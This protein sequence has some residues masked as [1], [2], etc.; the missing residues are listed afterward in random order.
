MN[1]PR[2]NLYISDLDGTLLTPD[3]YFPTEAVNRLNHLIENGLK[4]T[5]ATARSYD[6]AH[7]V[8]S[9]VN[10]NLP[11]ILFNGVYLT[12]FQSGQNLALTA[13]LC[14]NVVGDLMELAKPLKLD[15][16]VYT[17]K[18]RHQVFY[19]N[20]TNDASKSYLD[21]VNKLGSKNHFQ[22]VSNFRFLEME[23]VPGML[24]IDTFS[25]LE[26]LY[27]ALNETHHDKVKV[28][29]AKDLS[30]PEFYWLQIFHPC[31]NKGNMLE[32]L[33]NHLKIPLEKTIVFG[34]YLNDLE[35][36]D[37]AGR[38]L[39]VANALPEVLAAADEV[40]GTNAD[41]AVVEYLEKQFS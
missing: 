23:N 41:L 12:D 7:P 17:Y 34:D 31:A 29:F 33:A 8:L 10:L 18:N 40:I 26:P 19:R 32:K 5:I 37:V 27:R 24:F 36:F 2:E 28:Y 39:A 30:Q 38:A 9:R 4:F 20:L 35:M 6:S 13:S 14:P 22:Y 1:D 15:P 11:V 3:S 21:Y 16:F 25:V